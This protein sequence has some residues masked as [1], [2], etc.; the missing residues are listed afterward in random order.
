MSSNLVAGIVFTQS[1]GGNYVLIESPEQLFGPV[2][3]DL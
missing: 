1:G 2:E 3:R